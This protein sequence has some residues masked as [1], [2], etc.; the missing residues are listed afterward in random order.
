MGLALLAGYA[1]G[2]FDNL[3][4]AARQWTQTGQKTEPDPQVYELYRE[5]LNRYQAYIQSINDINEN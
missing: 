1:S 4:D 2:I 5:R 3:D